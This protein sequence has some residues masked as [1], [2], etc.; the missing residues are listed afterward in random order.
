MFV[1]GQVPEKGEALLSLEK[2]TLQ[3]IVAKAKPTR[4]LALS[5]LGRPK[6]LREVTDYASQIKDP[7][8]LIGGFPRGHFTEKTRKVTNEMFKVDEESLD[9]WVVAGR[10]VYDFEWSIGLAKSR[11]KQI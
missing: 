3:Q 6:L 9:A 11:V 7:M 5:K 2:M 1:E 4:V 10:F 8:V